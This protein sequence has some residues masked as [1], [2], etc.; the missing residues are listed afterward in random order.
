M[1]EFD[2]SEEV[3]VAQVAEPDVYELK[4]ENAELKKSDAGK[5]FIA[6][7]VQIR[8]DV[9]QNFAG[10]NIWDNIWKNEVHRNSTTGKRIKKETFET[11]SPADKQNIVT[12]M[13]YDDFKIRTLLHSQ[14]ENSKFKFTSIEEVAQFLNGLCFQAKITKDTDNKTGKEKNNLDYRT[15]KKT[16]VPVGSGSTS[17]VAVD[18][19]D[20]P[21]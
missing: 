11:M 19:N 17:D 18:D 6:L 15:I 2:Y 7:T 1:Q 8:D 5:E 3:S 4:I 9:E 20:L 10:V 14:D 13:E 21:F 12:R 16:T